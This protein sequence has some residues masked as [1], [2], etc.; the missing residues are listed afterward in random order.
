MF[1]GRVNIFLPMLLLC[2]FYNL[3]YFDL[4]FSCAYSTAAALINEA[5]G[6]IVEETSRMKRHSAKKDVRARPT[7][8]SFLRPLEVAE[9]E[10]SRPRTACFKPNWGFRKQD[11]VVGDTKHAKDWSLHSITP[12]DYKDIVLG[13]E[14]E[15]IELLGAQAMA[16][17]CFFL[18]SNPFLTQKF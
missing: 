3:P 16:A 15:T 9:P 18:K 8:P 11:T 14:L 4:F 10:V 1:L 6:P 13:K 17:V 2:I 5:Q 12:C 7:E